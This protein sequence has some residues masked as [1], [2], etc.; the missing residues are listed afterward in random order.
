[1]WDCTAYSS[2]KKAESGDKAAKS[3]IIQEDITEEGSLASKCKWP[4]LPALLSAQL[5]CMDDL[6]FCKAGSVLPQFIAE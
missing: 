6:P 3:K 4:I 2:D 1:M 5:H